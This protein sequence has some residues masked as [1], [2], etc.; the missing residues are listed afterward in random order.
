MG[1]GSRPWNFPA[2]S[3]RPAEQPPSEISKRPDTFPQTPIPK[4]NE[5]DPTTAYIGPQ[6]PTTKVAILLPLSGT[7][8]N[9]GDSMLKASQLALFDLGETNFELI[10]HDT[11][12]SAIGARTAAQNA[13]NDGASLILGPLFA[14]SV[15][16]AKSV[17]QSKN[18]NMI[19]FSTD[20]TLAGGNT[21]IMGFLPFDQIE[22]LTKYVAEQNIRHIGLLTPQNSYGIAVKKAY[23]NL[24]PRYG[25]TTTKRLEFNPNNINLSPQLKQFAHY[26]DDQTTQTPP[27]F[28][29]V[30]MPVGGS[31]ASTIS[32]TLSKY[33]LSPR[34]VKRLGTGLMDDQNLASD[35]AMQGTWFA[36]PSPRL[37]SN[38]EQKYRQTFGAPAPRLSTLAYDAT[39]LA[40]VLAQQSLKNRQPS[41]FTYQEITNPNGFYGID[42]VFRF[43]RD[44]TAERGLAI[45]EINN[46]QF[47]VI[48]PAPKTFEATRY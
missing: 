15:R 5:A 12:G 17:T 41:R 25:I 32:N 21:F 30:L 19:A 36:A 11:Q 43:N 4:T 14:E 31:Q 7:H 37:R 3:P 39:A 24:A 45:L 42:G 40:A 2:T 38:F 28:D 34:R 22:R 9:L 46:G 27:P 20:W 8:K 16:A 44:G 29:A 48:D 47:K 35:S 23:E 10:P 18:I 6:G 1:Y 13:I 26:T 33:N